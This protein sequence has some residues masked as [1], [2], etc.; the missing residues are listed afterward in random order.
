MKYISRPFVRSLRR[1][2]RVRHREVPGQGT[3]IARDW[4]RLFVTLEVANHD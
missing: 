2:R 3:E 4:P 1:S